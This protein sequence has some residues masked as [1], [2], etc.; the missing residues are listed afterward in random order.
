M[1]KKKEKENY[2]I[3]MEILCMKV[4]GLMINLKG[5][6]NL[7]NSSILQLKK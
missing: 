1:V 7:Y 6:K 3:K 5:S 2:I 4:T